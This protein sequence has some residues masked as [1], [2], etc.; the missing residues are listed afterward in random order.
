[1]AGLVNN[2]GRFNV[3]SKAELT[4]YYKAPAQFDDITQGICG[5]NA[6]YWAAPAWDYCTGLGAPNGKARQ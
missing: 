2:Q 6:G 5:P 4:Q 3:S 1:V